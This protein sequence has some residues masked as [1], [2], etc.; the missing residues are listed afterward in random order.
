[1]REYWL[2]RMYWLYLVVLACGFDNT[3]SR[4]SDIAVILKHKNPVCCHRFILTS[5]SCTVTRLTSQQWRRKPRREASL[6][7]YETAAD[8]SNWKAQDQDLSTDGGGGACSVFT[9]SVQQI[10]NHHSHKTQARYA[11]LCA[12]CRCSLL[13]V[14]AA[15]GSPQITRKSAHCTQYWL[16][17]PNGSEVICEV[18][19]ES[20]YVMVVHCRLQR[21]YNCK[22]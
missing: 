1:M 2:Y 12:V 18:Q 20:L 17:L 8:C 7:S 4:S 14:P 11:P 10:N 13:C 22:G 19:T 9:H 16:G 3:S 5:R 6:M 21:K 15:T